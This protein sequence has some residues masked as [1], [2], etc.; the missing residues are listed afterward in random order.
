VR[1]DGK[2]LQQAPVT[3]SLRVSRALCRSR[4]DLGRKSRKVIVAKVVAS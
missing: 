1:G 2:L 3:P 4:R